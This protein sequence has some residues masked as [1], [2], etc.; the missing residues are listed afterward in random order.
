MG[1]KPGFFWREKSRVSCQ[2]NISKFE[3]KWMKIQKL[4]RD[5]DSV[6]NWVSN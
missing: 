1:K 5:M 6:Q 3:I 2:T 4:D